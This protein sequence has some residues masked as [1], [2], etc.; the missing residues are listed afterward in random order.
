MQHVSPQTI[1]H[2]KTQYGRKG[3]YI[4]L[5][6]GHSGVSKGIDYLV[7]ALP[8]IIQ[9]NPDGIVVFNLIPAKR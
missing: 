5:Y 7:E 3:K 1:A 2:R 6:Y 9:N 4:I 8:E